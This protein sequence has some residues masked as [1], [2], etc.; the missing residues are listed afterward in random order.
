MKSILVTGGA[1]FIGSNFVR[2]VLNAYPSYRVIVLDALTY[3]GNRENLGE[4][5]NNPRFEFHHGDIRDKATVDKLM[6]RVGAV[7]NFAAETH[8]DRSIHEAGEF[9]TTDVLGT[10]VLLEAGKKNEIERFVQVSTDEVYGS[11]E[12]GSVHET[13]PLLPSSPYSASKAGGDML[14][15]S[16]FVT[17]G[18][19]ILITRGSNTFGPYQFP[20]KLIPLFVTNAIDNTPLPLYGDG[21]NVRDWLFVLDHCAAVDVVLHRGTAGEVYNIGGGNERQ[22]IYITQRILEHLHKPET[23][24]QPVKDRL[25]HD[26]RYSL[27]CDKIKELGWE[28]AYDFDSALTETIDWYVQNQSWWRKLKEKSE[29]FKRFYLRN[30]EPL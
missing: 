27:N 29:E 16:Y 18:M 9:I 17:Y 23:L 11:I 20:E 6:S 24:I 21:K 10:F 8:V 28:P 12:H 1:G 4:V 25:G 15:R 14:V 19:P 22:N 2:Y 3:A 30:Y 7:V 13:S 5:E 26:R